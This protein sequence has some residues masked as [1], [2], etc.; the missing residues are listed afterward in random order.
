[1]CA[2]MK[3]S[4]ILTYAV[5]TTLCLASP[6]ALAET[7]GS[8]PLRIKMGAKKPDAGGSVR[9]T[10]GKFFDKKMEVEKEMEKL[11]PKSRSSV[12]LKDAPPCPFEIG[13]NTPEAKNLADSLKAYMKAEKHDPSVIDDIYAASKQTGVDFGL[14][15][16][17][18]KIESDLGR[19]TVSSTS[20]ARGLFQFIDSTWLI[21][22]KQHGKDAGLPEYADALVFD[23]KTG[24]IDVPEDSKI[25]RQKILDLRFDGRI[26]SLLKAF[27]VRDEKQSVEDFNNGEALHVTDHYIAHMLGLGLSEEFYAMKN[28]ESSEIL[29]DSQNALFQE[30]VE[31]NPSFFYD[32][33]QNA[34][35]APESYRLFQ[36]RVAATIDWMNGVRKKYGTDS[37]FTFTPCVTA[38]K[39]SP[40]GIAAGEKLPRIRTVMSAKYKKE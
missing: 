19:N 13:A 21:L 3:F 40:Y 20:S 37:A 8:K 25:S 9:I 30:A 10:S 15:A 36:G 23:E 22:V 28:A 4:F 16:L 12:F 14:L 17:T 35:T 24:K 2:R 6:A 29:A 34:M 27:Q 5:I 39:K 18:A 33:E 38:P 7:E 1:M 32:G 26:A 11:R 31:L